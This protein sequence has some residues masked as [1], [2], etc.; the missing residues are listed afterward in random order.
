MRTQL[1]YRRQSR[2]TAL[3]A[4]RFWEVLA[5]GVFVH[6][7]IGT[8]V[9]VEGLIS[10]PLIWLV[11]PAVAASFSAL[12]FAYGD[13]CLER[14]LNRQVWSLK[15]LASSVVAVLLIL[16]AVAISIL[17]PE[18]T[19]ER[20]SATLLVLYILAV[21]VARLHLTLAVATPWLAILALAQLHAGSQEMSLY[22][23]LFGG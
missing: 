16:P 10:T 23:W 15:A 12:L 11:M 2:M 20:V 4:W 9:V 3:K 21:G 13:E 18:I 14:T 22:R 19:V 6:L 7:A 5:G 1:G 8:F 17:S